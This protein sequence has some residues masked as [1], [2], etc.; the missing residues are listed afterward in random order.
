VDRG[1]AVASSTFRSA[2]RAAWDYGSWFGPGSRRGALVLARA[3][4]G[5]VFCISKSS[6]LRRA[7]SGL[8]S[9]KAA[10]HASINATVVS[11]RRTRF[12]IVSP[13]IS[14]MRF[15][16]AGEVVGTPGRSVDR[17]FAVASSTFRSAPRAAWD[18]GSWFGPGS[19]RGS[20]TGPVSMPMRALSVGFPESAFLRF[21]SASDRCIESAARAA[22]SASFSCATG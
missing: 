15:M 2:P 1:F 9:A 11:A 5:P 10:P 8:S 6:S 7:I 12:F 4:G 22:R 18:Y 3:T 17:G 19:R 13:P 20:T 16:I 21:N 14:C